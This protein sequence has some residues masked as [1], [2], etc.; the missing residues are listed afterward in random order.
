[1]RRGTFQPNSQRNTFTVDQYH[2]LCT[3]ATLGFSHCRAPFFAGAKL[4]SRNASSHFS[5][6]F[7]SKLP[8]SFRQASSQTPFSSHCCSRRQQVEGEGNS[9]GRKRQAAPVCKIHKIPSKQARLG[10]GGRPRLPLGLG[11]GSNGSTNNHCSSFNSFCR[12]FITE[13]QPLTCLDVS[14]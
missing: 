4:P 9:S 8:S 11:A 6:P 10:A 5:K 1:M 13:A 2:P 12:F 7:W 14:T 3:L